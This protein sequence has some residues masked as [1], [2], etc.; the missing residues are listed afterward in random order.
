[1]DDPL[2]NEIAGSG[3]PFAAS[4]STLFS[5]CSIDGKALS[6]LSD[7]DRGGGRFCIDHF[8]MRVG[9]RRRSPVIL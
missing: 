6:Q 1:M 5:Y 2:R 9:N 8:R 3:G 4:T 7:S